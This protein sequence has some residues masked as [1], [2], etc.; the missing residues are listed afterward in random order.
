MLAPG[1]RFV[2]MDVENDLWIVDSDDQLL[3]R[4]MVRA[5]ADTVANPSIGRSGR[6]LLSGAGFEDVTVEFQ[7]HTMTTPT[8]ALLEN[9][10][11]AALER[12]G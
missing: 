9:V 2:L 4:T 12:S 11:A 10:V 5:L 6:A 1:G 8:A 3:A 7:P